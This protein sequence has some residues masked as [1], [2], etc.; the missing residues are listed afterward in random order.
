MEDPAALL[1]DDRVQQWRV[2]RAVQPLFAAELPW[3]PCPPAQCGLSFENH[4][5]FF[6][7]EMKTLPI[8]HPDHELSPDAFQDCLDTL[9]ELLEFLESVVNDK[10]LKEAEDAAKVSSSVPASKRL[11]VT[12][13]EGT[14]MFVASWLT[15]MSTSFFP[16]PELGQSS[17][18]T[19]PCPSITIEAMSPLPPNPSPTNEPYKKLHA[20]GKIVRE[21]LAR[22]GDLVKECQRFVKLEHS[23]QEFVEARNLA[24]NVNKCLESVQRVRERVRKR[25][26]R[27]I[28]KTQWK[29]RRPWDLSRTLFRILNRRFEF[30]SGHRAMLQL[31]G[32][33]QE[34]TT[35]L[36][37]FDMF[38]SCCKDVENWQESRFTQL[39]RWVLVMSTSATVETDLRPS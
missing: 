32:F 23:V 36:T 22:G 6:R 11:P 26:A 2:L 15:S 10:V 31:N 35:A 12:K 13:Q 27:K 9:S 18:P 5:D 1:L 14:I 20:L 8:N 33:Q 34:D 30:C 25:V 28:P 3:R 29:D 39:P 37:T 38:L 24:T 4:V 19:L 17:D 16:Q 21:V 7:N